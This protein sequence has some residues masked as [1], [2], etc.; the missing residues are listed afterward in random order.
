M[1]LVA[2]QDIP[3]ARQVA[4]EICE[5]LHARALTQQRVVTIVS[6][7]SRNMVSYAGG[8]QMTFRVPAN[9]RRIVILA[10][11]QGPGISNL[12]DI[13]GGRYKS[14]SGLG[15]GIIGTRRL[16]DAFDIETGRNGTTVRVEVVIT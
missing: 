6:E 9:D 11:D 10:I 4:R 12:Q 5:S 2:E 15:L 14:R 7:L 3:R 1:T 8:G 16:A 13:L